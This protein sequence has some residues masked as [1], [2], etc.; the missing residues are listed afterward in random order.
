MEYT[1]ASIRFHFASAPSQP[2]Y[3]L[4]DRWLIGRLESALGLRE[5]VADAATSGY[6]LVAGEGD[7]VPG[8]IVDRYDRTAVI[9]LDGGAPQ[10]F[11]QPLA[12]A[13]WLAQRL[14]LEA[15]VLRPRGRATLGQVVQGTLPVQPVPFLENGLRLTADVIQGQKTGFFLDQRDNRALIQHLARGRR[16]L[17]LFSFNGGFS[18]A[19]GIGG[20]RDVTSVDIAPAAIAAATDLWLRNGL[21]PAGHTGIVADCFQFLETAVEEGRRW[22]LTICDPPSFA[23]SQQSLPRALNAYARLAERAARV[24]ESGGLLRLASCSSHVP[25]AEFERANLEA[26]GGRGE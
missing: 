11:Y 17:N 9:K 14:D 15:V 4:D 18:I 2:P 25:R 21:P 19:A 16:V 7:G 12:I 26:W 5:A 22:D 8:L 20:A 13:G 3:D 6:R 10:A 23:P 1:A 24:V